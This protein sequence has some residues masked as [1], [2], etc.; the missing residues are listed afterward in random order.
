MKKKIMGNIMRRKKP[1][2]KA[3]I[4]TKDPGLTHSP[5]RNLSLLHVK[6]RRSAPYSSRSGSTSRSQ[7][8]SS[9]QRGKSWY[10]GMN[11]KLGCYNR[12]LGRGSILHFLSSHLNTLSFFT[13]MI[14]GLIFSYLLH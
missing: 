10:T 3:A 12:G 14:G 11:Y 13:G 6:Q 7:A 8:E 2:V 9:P 1:D 4:K 5:L